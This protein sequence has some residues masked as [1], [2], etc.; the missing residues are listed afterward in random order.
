MSLEVQ[1]QEADTHFSIKAVGQYSL[2][3]LYDLFDRLKEE[4]EKRGA[5]A[6]ILDITEV[7]GTIPTVDMYMLGVYCY[8]VLKS[9]VRIAII[10]PD[11]GANKFLEN[12]T[13][14]RGLQVAVVPDHGAATKWV[15]R[16]Q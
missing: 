5:Q 12:V 11:G 1:I 13:R 10:F 9:W 8:R 14:N 6:V 4:S 2:A 3:N 7:A 15:N 16:D